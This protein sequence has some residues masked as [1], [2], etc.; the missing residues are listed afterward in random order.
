MSEELVVVSSDE[1]DIQS[2][3]MTIRGVQVMLDRDL[4][5]LYGVATGAL[6]QAVKR[7]IERF[8]KRFMFQMTPVEFENW[9][10]QSV[11]SNLSKSTIRMG[12]RKRPFVFTEHGVTMLASVLRS[13]TAVRVSIAI[14]DAFVAMRRAMASTGNVLSRLDTV[15]RRQITDQSRNEERFDQIFAKM[16]EGE[17]PLAQIFY[18]GKFT[19]TLCGTCHDRFI[20]I[21]RRE[22]FWS[23]ASLKDAGRLTFGVA[24]MG[25]EVIPG[26]LASIRKAAH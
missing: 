7:N 23:G 5:A 8:P 18:Q 12:L 10:S 4:A 22:I 16:S 19:K 20:I 9:K 2:R 24:Q 6:N 26:L 11:I 14:V 15:E 17:V 25:P 1:T 3:I 21:D 13:E